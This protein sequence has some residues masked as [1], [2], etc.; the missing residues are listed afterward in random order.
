M[1]HV[2]PFSIGMLNY[3]GNNTSTNPSKVSPCP[4]L[5]KSSPVSQRC[6]ATLLSLLQ[7]GLHV[8]H[9]GFERFQAT[10]FQLPRI[11]SRQVTTVTTPLMDGASSLRKL[12]NLRH[13]AMFEDF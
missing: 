7:A 9:C 12:T 2:H 8:P 3:H 11:N 13:P 6:P 4:F 10:H 5:N 1:G